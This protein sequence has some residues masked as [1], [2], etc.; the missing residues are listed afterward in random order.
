MRIDDVSRL[1]QT[2]ATER[3]QIGS[4]ST[5]DKKAGLRTDQ[6]EISNLALGLGGAGDE[7]LEALRSAVESGTYRVSSTALAGKLIDHHLKP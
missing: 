6:S 5:R 1:P 3:S 7:R 2:Q 4:Q